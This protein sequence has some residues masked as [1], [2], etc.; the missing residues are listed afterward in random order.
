MDGLE[1]DADLDLAFVEGLAG[2]QDDRDAVPGVVVDLE[3]DGGEGDGPGVRGDGV[4]IQVGRLGAVRGAGV[5]AH[6][7]VVDVDGLDGLEELHLLV[8]DGLG[9][10][11]LGLVHEQEGEDLEQ[12]VLHHVAD[13]ADGVEVAAAALCAEGLLEGDLDGVDV[14]VVPGGAET[15]VGEAHGDQVLDHLL[16][17][18]VVDAE[19]LVLG[20]QRRQVPLQLAG[21]VQ[22]VAKRLLDYESGVALGARVA[23]LLQVCRHHGEHGRRQREVVQPVRLRHPAGGVQLVHLLLQRLEPVR[24]VVR[25]PVVAAQRKELLERL[26]VRLLGL[27]VRKERRDSLPQTLVRQVR[28]GEPD[29][30]CRP[31]QPALPVEPEQR[32]ERLLLRQVPGRP[33]HHD[34]RVLVKPLVV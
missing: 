26:H 17:E 3:C 29:D 6:E 33:K 18:V 25:G 8:A 13:D 15:G 16:A 12:V 34:H 27:V 7:D 20:P 30:L 4:V 31:C 5:L 9:A 28:P 22:V 23:V 1:L 11:V 2:L 21:A 10:K 14:A 24:L 32:R 19:E